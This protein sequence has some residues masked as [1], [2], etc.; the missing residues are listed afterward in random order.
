VLQVSFLNWPHL[1]GR[2]DSNF[3]SDEEKDADF[4]HLFVHHGLSL[5]G[6]DL[7]RED[8]L[9]YFL[10][11]FLCTRERNRAGRWTMKGKVVN[12]DWINQMIDRRRVMEALT[13]PRS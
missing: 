4:F 3:K 1:A 8:L 10:L 2:K 12:R 5:D 9:S 11:L 13:S 6:R 7:P